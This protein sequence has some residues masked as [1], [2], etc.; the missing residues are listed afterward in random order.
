MKQKKLKTKSGTR[1][2]AWRTR[3]LAAFAVFGLMLAGC[4]STP[5]QNQQE[6]PEESSS[7]PSKVLVAYYSATGNT[8]KAA[9]MIAAKTDGTLFE[10]TP[11][12]PYTD[13]DLNYNDP[14]SRVSQEHADEES[15]NVAIE[16][17]TPEDFD[18]YD[19]IFLGFP[20]WWNQPAWVIDQFVKDNDFTGKIVYPFGT[21]A[22]SSIS[23]SEEVLKAMNPEINWQ[24]ARRFSQS[25]NDDEVQEW[26]DSLN[27]N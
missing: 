6:Q 9:E 23:N 24:S 4:S 21:S 16:T 19:V 2:K 20:I 13:E 22:S 8:K 26:I 15:Q 18:S 11:Q 7:E 10:I 5:V 17:V 12:T 27:L 3:I 14:N 1:T 25:V